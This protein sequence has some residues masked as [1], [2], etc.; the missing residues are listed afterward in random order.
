MAEA[1]DGELDEAVRPKLPVA[2]GVKSASTG[3]A[4]IGATR[5]GD[6]RGHVA[7]RDHMLIHG[8]I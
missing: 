3:K 2:H 7:H 5:A 4:S 6:G 1:F 8:A